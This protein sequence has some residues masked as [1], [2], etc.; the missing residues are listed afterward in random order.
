MVTVVN[1]YF[2]SVDETFNPG[3]EDDNVPE[4]NGILN[5]YVFFFWWFVS[6]SLWKYNAVSV[7]LLQ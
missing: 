7:Q 2:L 1:I 5:F 6:F 4:D 3:E